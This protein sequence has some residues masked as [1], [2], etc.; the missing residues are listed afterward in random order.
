MT[1]YPLAGCGGGGVD[2]AFE[3]G[4]TLTLGIELTGDALLYTVG[5]AA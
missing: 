5:L 4:T 1:D 2:G 3:A